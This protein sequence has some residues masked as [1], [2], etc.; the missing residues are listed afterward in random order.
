MTNTDINDRTP[1][2]R[3]LLAGVAAL[4]ALLLTGC[5]NRE[6]KLT[7]TVAAANAAADRAE[8]AAKRAEAAAKQGG[9]DE[10]TVVQEVEPEP[11]E[12]APADE[13]APAAE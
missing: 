8:A 11:E 1:T 4:S 2:R 10:E 7:E 9:G 12:A 3:A 13:P 6:Q 5:D